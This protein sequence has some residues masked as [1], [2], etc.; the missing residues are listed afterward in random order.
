M[1][2]IFVVM[3]A[4]EISPQRKFLCLRYEYSLHYVYIAQF[5]LCYVVV[6]T[7]CLFGIHSLTFHICTGTSACTT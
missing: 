2:L 6:Q 7:H 4:H 1:G 3:L 5:N